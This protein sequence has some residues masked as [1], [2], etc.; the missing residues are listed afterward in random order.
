MEQ[1]NESAQKSQVAAYVVQ[2]ATQPVCPL[3]CMPRL[4]IERSILKS[5]MNREVHVRFCEEQGVKLPLLTRLPAVAFTVLHLQNCQ[6][7]HHHQI[8]LQS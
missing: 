8:H 7:L 1:T 2:N 5:R 4:L 3:E 6:S